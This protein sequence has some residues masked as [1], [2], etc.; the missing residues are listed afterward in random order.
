MDRSL[1]EIAAEM[2]SG[3]NSG[4]IPFGENYERRDYI[5]EPIRGSFT[6][7]KRH[8][9]YS[10]DRSSNKR[11]RGGEKSGCRIFVANLSFATTHQS[12][13]EHMRK[14]TVW[15]GGLQHDVCVHV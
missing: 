10:V 2:S 9:P 5:G 7:T 3:S 8:T 6:S 4:H 15:P 14:G 1:D 12:F 11:D 13:R